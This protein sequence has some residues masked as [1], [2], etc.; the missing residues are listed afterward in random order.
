MAL[1][2]GQRMQMYYHI[3]EVYMLDNVMSTPWNGE[4]VLS[5]HVLSSHLGRARKGSEFQ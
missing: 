1:L 2:S 3:F 4:S 5:T